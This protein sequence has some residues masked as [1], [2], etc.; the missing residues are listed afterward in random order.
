[1]SAEGGDHSGG[2]QTQEKKY[3]MGVFQLG[4]DVRL[5]ILSRM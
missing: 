4:R 1:V 2:L 5:F 3:G